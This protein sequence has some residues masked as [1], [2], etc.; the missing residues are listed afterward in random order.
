MRGNKRAVCFVLAVLLA[1]GCLG[2]AGCAFSVDRGNVAESR[3]PDA[4]QSP[5]PGISNKDDINTSESEASEEPQLQNGESGEDEPDRPRPA[6]EKIAVGDGCFKTTA[7]EFRQAINVQIGED[8]EKIPELEADDGWEKDEWAHAYL[9]N[10][11][12]ISLK[13]S[14]SSQSVHMVSFDWNKYS[15]ADEAKASELIDYY[16]TAAL[17]CLQ[18]VDDEKIEEY[19]ETLD[20]GYIVN[21]KNGGA[22]FTITTGPG[23]YG[24]LMTVPSKE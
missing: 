8:E 4:V 7:E 18:D 21:D 6:D 3:E 15:E 22:P 24:I 12:W 11:V 5:T 13:Y 23:K 16:F 17:R 20:A 2:M 9:S 10:G 1:L 14:K 19:K